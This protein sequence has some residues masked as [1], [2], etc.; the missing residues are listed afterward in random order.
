MKEYL[1]S[2]RRIQL[3]TKDVCIQS[4]S[5]L[6][7]CC[8]A[9]KSDV[10]AKDLSATAKRA[11]IYQR[12]QEKVLKELDCITLVT[13]LRMLDQMVSLF[14]TSHQKIML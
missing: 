1:S 3:K 13:R 7:I 2:R 9:K 12:G 6:L 8:R 5:R 11:N 14:F 10:K 4:F